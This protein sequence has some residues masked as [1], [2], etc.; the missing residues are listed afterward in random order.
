MQYSGDLHGSPVPAV[1]V[2]PDHGQSDDRFSGSPP[3]SSE[4]VPDS[5]LQ[6]SVPHTADV[7]SAEAHLS[8]HGIY[9]AAPGL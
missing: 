8:C 5:T 4:A 3:L 1:S 2:H 9:F 7:I 6:Y